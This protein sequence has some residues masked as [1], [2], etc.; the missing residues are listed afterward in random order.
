MIGAGCGRVGVEVRGGVR[1]GN[2][3]NRQ[4]GG[5]LRG[6]GGRRLGEG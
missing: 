2:E 4:G 1:P 5:R 3:R 6:W